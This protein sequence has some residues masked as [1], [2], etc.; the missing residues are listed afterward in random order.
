MPSGLEQMKQF[1]LSMRR[2]TDFLP[3][4]AVC[5]AML[6][7]A[8]TKTPADTPSDNKEE[9]TPSK[10]DETPGEDDPTITPEELQIVDLGLSVK[11]ASKNLEAIAPADAG[12]K[13]AWA[14]I[15]AKESFS[16]ENYVWGDSMEKYNET[17][18]KQTLDP[19]DD[20]ATASLGGYWR[21]P[22]KQEWEELRSTS[23]C[24][25]T[26][27]EKDGI[28]GYTVTSLRNGN[29]IFLPCAKGAQDASYWSAS[30][31]ANAVRSAYFISM[32]AGTT[33]VLISARKSGYPIRP[34]YGADFRIVT[35]EATVMYNTETI[36]VEVV[37]TLDYHITST[38]D[39]MEEVSSEELGL[40]RKVHHFSIQENESDESR[41]G[42]IVF[43]NDDMK[44]VPYK[45]TQKQNQGVNWNKAFFHRSLIMRFTATWCPWCPF[46]A[47]AVQ[48]AQAQRP[49]KI[50]PLN[51]HA[52]D[53]DL[54]F[55]QVTPL[56]SQYHLNGYPT[57]YV[58]GRKE[59][60]NYQ[61]TGYTASLIVAALEETEDNY[62]VTSAI[63]INSSL[64]GST[65]NIDVDLFLRNQETY[66]VTVVVTES[67]I[68]H[69]Q[70]DNHT[71]TYV[72]DYRHD[73]IAR[74]A[75][76][77]VK[78]EDVTSPAALSVIQKKYSTTIPSTYNKNNLKVLVYVQRAF[79]SQPVLS[80]SNY[81]GYYVDNAAVANVG[82]EVKPDYA[83]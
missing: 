11:W 7:S 83:D 81:G 65:L 42:V 73:D 22:S 25:W 15:N 30:L 61:D 51:L 41:S 43:C 71:G 72:N 29:S 40:N 12:A 26:W 70:A 8:C 1:N 67:G 58:D 16:W 56:E 3:A 55:N 80:T 49:G 75:V 60:P 19:E 35:P 32:D 39:W 77:N 66:K 13:F 18:G 54:A 44:C 10:P 82:E 4:A 62:P 63:G 14:E 52:S 34:V 46:M 33:S 5:L 23:N 48:K 31:S 28:S 45:V 78:G 20:A 47:E 64:S 50:L 27:S 53:S 24:T 69:T 6:F 38:P 37:S 59:I 17:D 36:D 68:I 9:D 2:L 74:I 21:M 79:G 57:G 76:T